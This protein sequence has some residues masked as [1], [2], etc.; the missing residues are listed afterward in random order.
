MIEDGEDWGWVSLGA[1][2]EEVLWSLE[3]G[4]DMLMESS[5]T[6]CVYRGDERGYS[7]HG[8]SLGY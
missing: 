3:T 4:S 1:V 7:E 5:H 6:V 8:E 2:I